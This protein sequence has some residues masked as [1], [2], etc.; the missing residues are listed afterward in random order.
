MDIQLPTDAA[1]F[2]ASVERHKAEGWINLSEDTKLFVCAYIKHGYSVAA[3]VRASGDR[4]SREEAHSYLSDPLVQ[5]AIADVGNQYAEVSTFTQVGLRAK[6]ARAL[7]IALGEIPRAFV[8]KD[9]DQ[10]YGFD[11]DLS[12]AAKL[13]AMAEKHV[14]SDDSKVSDA[15]PWAADEDLIDG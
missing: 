10:Y 2:K 15:T 5:A 7:D 8:T 6:L 4:L 13:I 3:M 9:G 14:D 12:A 11:V 1:T